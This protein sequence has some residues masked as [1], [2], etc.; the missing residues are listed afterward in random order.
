MKTLIILRGL[1]GKEKRDWVEHEGL[2]DFFVDISDLRKLYSSPEL[3]A[4]GHSIL[5]RSFGDTVWTEYI[6]VLMFRLSRGCLVVTDIDSDNTGAIENLALIFGYTVF[7]VVFPIPQDYLGKPKKYI[8]SYAPVKRRDEMEKEVISYLNQQYHGKN[9]ITCFQD[10]EDYWKGYG[11]VILREEAK[12]LH[13]SDL[14]SNFGLFKKLPD[15]KNYDFIVFHGDY[16]DGPE[17]GGS[18]QLMDYALGNKNPRVLWLEGNH[19]LRLRRFLG[20]VMLKAGG[21]KELQS[22]LLSSVPS[23]FLDTTAKEFSDISPAG[24]RE[25]LEKI[26]KTLMTC[27]ILDIG[28]KEFYCTHAGLKTPEQLSP[29]WIGNVIYGNRDMNRY[30]REFS[31]RSKRLG[32]W[33]IHAHCKYH[34]QWCANKYNRV[35][36][37]DPPSNN[38]IVYGEQQLQNW[39]ICQLKR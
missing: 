7:Y 13:V 39:N 21:G 2:G 25:Y 12:T 8:P 30:D 18:R 19:E 23:D 34:D 36:N 9:Q 10:I 35:I 26:N 28:G 33:S 20:S 29:G 14:H 6:K 11:R 27:A 31:E 32:L 37:L 24:A 16:I 38:E 1:A 4:P 22:L 3:Q 5:S 17:V 15:L